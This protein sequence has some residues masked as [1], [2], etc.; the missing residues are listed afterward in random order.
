MEK[1]IGLFED[2]VK[3]P[4]AVLVSVILK[5]DDEYAAGKSLDELDRLLDTAGGQ[6]FARITQNRETPDPKTYIG[7]GK[8]REIAE[9]VNNNKLELVIFDCNLTPTQIKNLENEL[10]DT[11]V[12]DRTMLILDIFALH[13]TTNEGK[14]Q[15]ELAQLKYT[16]PRLTGKGLQLSRQQGGGGSNNIATRGPGETK[17]ETDRR[18]LK[19]R[20]DT[21]EHEL[22]EIEKNRHVQR[23]QRN[24]SGIKKIAIAGYT[25]AGKSTLLNYLTNAGVLS[26]DKL[27][28]TLD[29]TT[30]KFE[31]PNGV[32]IL[33]TDT[34]GFIRNLPHHLVKAFKSTLEE[35]SV[36]DIILII[37]DSSD[38]ECDAQLEVTEKLLEELNAGDKPV[39]Y[40]YNK[41][42]LVGEVY[43][44]KNDVVYTSMK[45]GYGTDKLVAKLEELVMEGQSDEVF[46]IPHE[47]ASLVGKLFESSAVREVEY[48]TEHIVVTATVDGKTKGLM[49]NY[50]R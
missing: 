34:V 16:A 47:K 28:A 24:R 38:S 49:K 10:D 37:I 18:H 41:C 42:D 6:T 4:E 45:T 44:D 15:V 3:K 2:S 11:R 30:R 8:I 31:L 25:N 12:I 27:F 22:A 21:L 46:F 48:L 13:A 39:I 32:E 40:V 36:A 5:D 17:L 29:P 50:I 26:E 35:V 19:R 20:I 7:S 23:S 9:I 14:V 1:N 33:L 43:S